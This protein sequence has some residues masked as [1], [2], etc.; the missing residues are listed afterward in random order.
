[1]GFAHLAAVRSR[2]HGKKRPSGCSC[3]KTHRIFVLKVGASSTK[4]R[5]ASTSV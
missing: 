3:L 4:S 2:L 5:L 1:V